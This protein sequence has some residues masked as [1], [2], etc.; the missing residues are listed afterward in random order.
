MELRRFYYK[1]D[2]IENVEVQDFLGVAISKFLDYIKRPVQY[3]VF[4]EKHVGNI[5]LFAYEQY[6]DERFWWVIAVA[7]GI[8][9]PWDESFIGKRCRIPS[10][11]DV[12]DFYRDHFNSEVV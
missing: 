12:F 10:K 3:V 7:N 9:D 11:Q 5:D 1:V 8:E 4:H 2:I 6:G